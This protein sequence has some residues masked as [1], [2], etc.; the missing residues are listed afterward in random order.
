MLTLAIDT[1]SKTISIA[2]LEDD[3]IRLELLLN[4][5]LHHSSL[6]LPAI[7]KSC[8][9]TKVNIEQIDLMVCTNGPGSFTGLRIGISTIIGLALASRKPAIG[10]STLEALAMNMSH[11]PKIICPMMDAQKNE[12]YTAL[13]LTGESGQLTR[14]TEDNVIDIASF[15][16]DIRY[17][18]DFL[19]DGAIKYAD[20][21]QK[22][23]SE[24]TFSI[25][26]QDSF[27]K[28]SNV[29][30][31][32]LKMFVEGNAQDLLVLKPK[33]LRLSEAEIKS[34]G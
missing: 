18:V 3:V 14:I 25:S 26:L 20:V 16:K 22:T 13:F 28:A 21:I 7:K 30:L 10:V 24:N 5:G 17:D 2:F 15:L 12:I 6:L 9:L 23:L 11:S 19:G 33:Y 27:V 4:T 34:K 1:S 29:G 32:G 31:I 8:E